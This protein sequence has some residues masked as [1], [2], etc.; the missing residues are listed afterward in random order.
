MKS[1]IISISAIS[2]SLI[3]I[4]LTLG[5]YIEVIDL[6]SV[7]TSSVFVI[8]PL[9]YNSYKGCLLC[10]ICGGVIALICSLPTLSFSIVMPAYFMF[11]GIYPIVKN[12]LNKNNLKKLCFFIGLVWCVCTSFVLYFYYTAIIGLTI[13]NLPAI[14]SEY[15]LAFV[16]AVAVIFYLIF[17]RF[18]F[19]A[20]LVMDKYIH[21]II[22]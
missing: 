14:V 7:V 11:F 10:Y 18:I 22:K 9:Y 5:C 2:A 15:I 8:L 3:A 6:I 1:K 19:V 4:C 17:D 12:M 13:A 21:K 20:K 16:C